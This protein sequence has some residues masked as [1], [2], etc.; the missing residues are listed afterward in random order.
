MITHDEN[1]IVEQ[2]I[3]R[4]VKFAAGFYHFVVRDE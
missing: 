1:Y 2:L 3:V 4:L